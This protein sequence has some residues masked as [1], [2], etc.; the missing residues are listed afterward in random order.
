[1]R[2]SVGRLVH[3]V[4]LGDK[5]GKYPPQVQAAVITGIY[6]IVSPDKRERINDGVGGPDDLVS[7][8]VDLKVFYKTGLFDCENIP[9]R[10]T[11]D[12][13]GC[14]DWPPRV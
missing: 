5:D 3:Y 10:G 14:W 8:N 12:Q 2:P 7:E 11:S 13:R 6:R 1:M 9:L 4:N